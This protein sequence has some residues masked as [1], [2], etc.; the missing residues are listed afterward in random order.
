MD[1]PGTGPPD[2]GQAGSREVPAAI[3]PA[4]ANPFLFNPNY[5]LPTSFLDGTDLSTYSHIVDALCQAQQQQ[6]N[7]ALGT[8]FG[9]NHHHPTLPLTPLPALPSSHD[10]N[11][12]LTPTTPGFHASMQDLLLSPHADTFGLF[13]GH[14][15]AL[16]GYPAPHHSFSSPAGTLAT[17]SYAGTAEGSMSPTGT[18]VPGDL[19]S[20]ALLDDLLSMSTGPSTSSPSTSTTAATVA[21]P[22]HSEPRKTA[23]PLT[24]NK[25]PP[26][27]ANPAQE[28]A[29]DVGAKKQKKTPVRAPSK[30][31]RKRTAPPSPPLSPPQ[32]DSALSSPPPVGP[33][34]SVGPRK[35]LAPAWGLQ[36]SSPAPAPVNTLRPLAAATLPVDPNTLVDGPPG[37]PP[38]RNQRRIAHNAIERRYRNNI[39][40]RIRELKDSIP[41][42]VH[43]QQ[44]KDEENQAT[45]ATAQEPPLRE[46]K[47]LKNTKNLPKEVDGIAPAA[48]LNKATVLRKATE[49]V[50][51]LRRAN[52]RLR[53]QVEAL[54]VLATTHVPDADSRLIQI[55]QT[56]QAHADAYIL[57]LQTSLALADE[58]GEEQ[59]LTPPHSTASGS[60]PAHTLTEP[61]PSSALST[62]S[63]SDS[64]GGSSTDVA[65]AHAVD[66][67]GPP[68]PTRPTG[69]P[70]RALL[71]GLL[72]ASFFLAAPHGHGDTHEHRT[73]SALPFVGQLSHYAG[74]TVHLGDLF[75]WLRV[76]LFVTCL[77]GLLFYDDWFGRDR[78]AKAA[79]T[80]RV[81]YGSTTTASTT[82]TTTDIRPSGTTTVTGST[83]GTSRRSRIRP[84]K[85]IIGVA[86]AQQL[87]GVSELSGTP[88][89]RSYHTMA[90]RLAG[91]LTRLI[92]PRACL[93]EAHALD[94]SRGWLRLSELQLFHE[95]VA[96]P[97][98]MKLYTW[99][100]AVGLGATVSGFDP[101]Q[102]WLVAA[103]HVHK[104]VVIRYLRNL[105][106]RRVWGWALASRRATPAVT[107][108]AWDWFLTAPEAC[109]FFVDGDWKPFTRSSG[110]TVEWPR[111]RL[112]FADPTDPLRTCATLFALNRTRAQLDYYLRADGRGDSTITTTVLTDLLGH[113]RTGGPDG[114]D[115]TALLLQWY[116]NVA[117]AVVAHKAGR[118]AE[119][120]GFLART[121][122]L[123]RAIHQR[124]RSG[125][126]G[127][128]P[129]ERRYVRLCQEITYLS[130][131]PAVL[132]A[133]G[134]FDRARQICAA[135]PAR[136]AHRRALELRVLGTA[137][138]GSADLSPADVD[139]SLE[140]VLR[141]QRRGTSLSMLLVSLSPAASTESSAPAAANA[142]PSAAASASTS[143]TF[144]APAASSLPLG[145]SAVTERRPG[146]SRAIRVL[147]QYTSDIERRLEFLVGNLVMDAQYLCWHA[148]S[149]A[150]VPSAAVAPS[151]EDL[152]GAA[153]GSLSPVTSAA[154]S[155]APALLGAHSASVAALLHHLA[156]LRPLAAGVC[157]PAVSASYLNLYEQ[158]AR[159]VLSASSPVV[160]L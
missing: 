48:K 53:R 136:L 160:G 43:V 138:G 151:R 47:T 8:G 95:D 149:S 28:P 117:L 83:E 104:S 78:R 145:G 79:R 58:Y 63:S 130:L 45:A 18:V 77:A 27:D 3:S 125:A 93:P 68:G 88:L 13:G 126:T 50:W 21:S 23:L 69:F 128:S 67:R 129:L 123:A 96:L 154:V 31:T 2:E 105:A 75:R 91:E 139:A 56:S 118:A 9:G 127:L 98:V 97:S 46:S 137:A 132:A 59:A 85:T 32:G 109:T 7:L 57:Q 147:Y 64:D 158:M 44:I 37:A 5:G 29:A 142:A 113:V 60:P 153:T 100:R 121:L 80:W 54:H 94:L 143:S 116:L 20:T 152:T 15:A 33:A 115:D 10:F 39:N 141:E 25:R 14:G 41:A 134:E 6:Q 61:V 35:E 111:L 49:Y 119:C 71:G 17:M 156:Y 81:R 62:S 90:L 159:T 19:T 103:M 34:A 124:H 38:V 89:P 26:A 76:I 65:P 16:A 74:H 150:L 107:V 24:G 22:A 11:F 1:S 140:K 72:C 122:D 102:A 120:E 30:R 133:R 36:T 108:P 51:H 135:L 87:H 155:S 73:L 101:A 114:A 92:A 157:P 55:Q 70:G 4:D 42:L 131:L 12:A 84:A 112:V 82:T 110:H 146:D 99:L 52:D 66:A 86:Y 148:N 106:V 40:D 144:F